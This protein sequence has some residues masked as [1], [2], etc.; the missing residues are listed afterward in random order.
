MLS[1][2]SIDSTPGVPRPVLRLWE[3]RHVKNAPV[4]AP[5][6]LSLFASAPR[7][8]YCATLNQL[9]YVLTCM[10]STAQRNSSHPLQLMR[11]GS[12]PHQNTNFCSN[13]CKSYA[14]VNR[15]STF[16]RTTCQVQPKCGTRKMQLYFL[17][18]NINV[19]DSRR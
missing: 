7:P 9:P 11:K 17:K 6:V 3:P 10:L 13:C 2:E 5:R 14:G 19:L 1:P 8:I 16:V 18:L 4:C 15:S 12:E